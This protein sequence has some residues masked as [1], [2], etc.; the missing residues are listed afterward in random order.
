MTA[1][2][3]QSLNVDVY[4]LF[5]TTSTMVRLVRGCTSYLAKELTPSFNIPVRSRRPVLHW[6]KCEL[7]LVFGPK[8]N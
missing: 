5:T 2:E 8:S 7:K 3:N 1:W 4:I 6:N